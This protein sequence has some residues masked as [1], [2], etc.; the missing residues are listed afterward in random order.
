MEGLDYFTPEEQLE[1]PGILKEASRMFADTFGF[2]SDSFIANCYIWDS[3]QE[4]ELAKSGVRLLQG[5]SNQILPT[6]NDGNSYR[7]HYM[8]QK[9]NFGQFYLTRNAFFE[10]SIDRGKNCVEECLGRIRLAFRWGKPA[11]IA[12]HRLNYIGFIDSRNRDT[13]LRDLKVLLEQIVHNWPD[14]EFMSTDQLLP[15][16]LEKSE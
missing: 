5:I 1:K 8:G 4:Q 12:S 13:N 11:I 16:Y 10:P 15:N 6:S 2:K 3:L 9:N 14:V 7:R